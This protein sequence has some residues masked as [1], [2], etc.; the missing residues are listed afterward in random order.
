VIVVEPLQRPPLFSAKVLVCD[1]SDFIRGEQ[2]KMNSG[3][4]VEGSTS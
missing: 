2:L 3:S 4:M 1:A